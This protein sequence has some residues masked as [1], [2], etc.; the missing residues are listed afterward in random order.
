MILTTLP[1]KFSIVSL[2][3][4]DY[5]PSIILLD[6]HRCSA[7]LRGTCLAPKGVLLPSGSVEEPRNDGVVW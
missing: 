6:L 4:F 1:S 3:T 5:F 2:Y 7:S